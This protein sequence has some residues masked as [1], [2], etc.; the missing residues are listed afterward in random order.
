MRYEKNITKIF[1]INYT[2]FLVQYAVNKKKHHMVINIFED[3]N[4]LFSSI[5]R[6]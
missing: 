1:S 4:S 3:I 2:K 6:L 5:R